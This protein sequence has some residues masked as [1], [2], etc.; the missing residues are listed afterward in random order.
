MPST[1]SAFAFLLFGF[2]TGPTRRPSRAGGHASRE[3]HA[4]GRASGTGERGRQGKGERGGGLSLPSRR[5]RQGH[6]HA[7]GGF[8]RP[9]RIAASIRFP[10]RAAMHAR[11]GPTAP[12][13]HG[14]TASEG[15]P[16][17]TISS[18]G[19]ARPSADRVVP[20]RCCP[21]SWFPALPLR[22]CIAARQN[23]RVILTLRHPVRSGQRLRA[24]DPS[25]G[26]RARRSPA[27]ATVDR[28][29]RGG[30]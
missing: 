10:L 2:L 21:R 23:V 27:W 24:T 7:G 17:P 12:A 1:P 30:P 22:A 26:G 11:R 15:G 5:R 13:R 4:G 20:G 6:P 25:A 9:P 14:A 16:C 19:T 8:P 18:M 3:R 28:R 29:H